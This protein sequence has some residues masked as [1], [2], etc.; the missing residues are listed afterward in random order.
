MTNAQYEQVEQ[1]AMENG[2]SFSEQLRNETEDL[3]Y[4]HEEIQELQ[5]Q[6]IR[7]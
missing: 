4:G 7:R 6:G 3:M 1:R 2:I 5:S